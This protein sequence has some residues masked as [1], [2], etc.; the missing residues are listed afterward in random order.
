MVDLSIRNAILEQLDTLPLTSQ[1][2]VLDFAK[3]LSKPVVGTPG[4]NLLPLVGTMS[5]EYAQEMLDAIEEGCGR[6]DPNEW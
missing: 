3:G 4:V 6:V 2:A 5:D 1:R